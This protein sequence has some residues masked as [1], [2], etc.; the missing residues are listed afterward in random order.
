M[1][2]PDIEA[3]AKQPWM[4][5]ASDGG[6]AIPEDGPTVHARYYGTFP[7]KIRRY[8]LDRGVISLE[9]AI[10]SM[11]SLP[12]QI[13]G[14]QDRGVLREGAM[15][16]IAVLDLDRLTDKATFLDPHQHSEGVEYVLVNGQVVVDRGQPTGKLAGAALRKEPLARGTRGTIP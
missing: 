13:L 4:A 12:A 2:E 9:H 15:A 1:A 8:A 16:D 3:F 7:R 5:T 6:L 14:L 10:R 11:T